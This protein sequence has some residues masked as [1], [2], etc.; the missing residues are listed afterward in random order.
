MDKS[1]QSAGG[2]FGGGMDCSE[3]VPMTGIESSTVVPF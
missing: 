3:A 1:N 2:C